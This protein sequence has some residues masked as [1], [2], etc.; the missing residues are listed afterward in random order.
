MKLSKDVRYSI[1]RVARAAE[2]ALAALDRFESDENLMSAL[3]AGQAVAD[4]GTSYN[5][6]S[7]VLEA[8]AVAAIERLQARVESEAADGVVVPFPGMVH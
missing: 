1:E 5:I 7:A 3:E 6:L 2:S 4:I 8:E